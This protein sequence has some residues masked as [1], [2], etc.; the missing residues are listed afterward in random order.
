MPVLA[1]M[2]SLLDESD[3]ESESFR[4]TACGTSDELAAQRVLLAEEEDC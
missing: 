1:V 4:W 3:S 2:R